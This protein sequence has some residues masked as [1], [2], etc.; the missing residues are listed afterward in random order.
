MEGKESHVSRIGYKTF[1]YIERENAYETFVEILIGLR[2][3]YTLTHYSQ[4]HL[5]HTLFIIHK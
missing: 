3:L 5:L 4:M 1:S 2:R